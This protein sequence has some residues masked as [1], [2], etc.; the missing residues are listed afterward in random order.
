MHDFIY[1]LRYYGGKGK[2]EGRRDTVLLMLYIQLM[3]SLRPSVLATQ[4]DSQV[5]ALRACCLQ[6]LSTLNE[7]AE[8]EMGLTLTIIASVPET[9]TN[10]ARGDTLEKERTDARSR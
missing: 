5:A 7:S 8:R 4:L 1:V 9:L 6:A 3:L 2:R 10:V